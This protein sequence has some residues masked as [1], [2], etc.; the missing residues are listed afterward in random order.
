V[1]LPVVLDANEWLVFIVTI[2]LLFIFI[3]LPKRFP[4]VLTFVLLVFN[5]FLGT[6]VDYILAVNYPFN[7][8]DTFDTPQLDVMDCVLYS[9]V[10]PLYGYLFM[11]FYDKWPL[12]GIRRV[13]YMVT[14]VI[15]SVAFEWAAMHMHVFTYRN[16]KLYES[17]I[18]YLLIFP[19]NVL[20]LKISLYGMNQ[21]QSTAKLN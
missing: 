5:S 17:T 10:Y 19:I 21:I 1:N 6:T 13:L 2:I 16:W 7:F 14:W 8:Y 18:C 3:R 9:V 15:A 11:Y 20:F 12:S 4:T